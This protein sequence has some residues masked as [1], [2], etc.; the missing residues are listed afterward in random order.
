MF[1]H[2]LRACNQLPQQAVLRPGSHT[3]N[4]IKPPHI[5]QHDRLTTDHAT[6]QTRQTAPILSSHHNNNQLVIS[7][8]KP[9]QDDNP[10]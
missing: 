10:T 7:T 2:N 3:N 9:R 4:T 6:Q 1:A 8:Y 5:N